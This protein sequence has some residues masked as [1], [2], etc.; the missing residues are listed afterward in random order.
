[1]RLKPYWLLSIEAGRRGLQAWRIWEAQG[2]MRA[3]LYRETG[4]RLAELAR[5]RAEQC[6]VM[7]GLF[8]ALD[9][10]FPL[11]LTGPSRNLS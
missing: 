8:A 4:S 11:G 9:A 5:E 3:S 10:V 7:S 2:G 1:M 6:R